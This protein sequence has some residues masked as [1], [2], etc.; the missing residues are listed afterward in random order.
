MPA[1]ERGSFTVHGIAVY[2]ETNK[3]SQWNGVFAGNPIRQLVDTATTGDSRYS[4]SNA[5]R[6]TRKLDTKALHES[7]RKEYRAF[8][9]RHP[10][11]SEVWY[12]QQ[13]AKKDVAKGRSAE[14]IRKHMNR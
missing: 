4:P 14:T 7:W 11:M 12:S 10:G 5:R 9:K 6:E 8:K 13:I 2:P 3:L 1:S